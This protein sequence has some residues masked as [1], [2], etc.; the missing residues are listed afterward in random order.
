MMIT[1]DI[2]SFKIK[3]LLEFAHKS[4]EIVKLK[5]QCQEIMESYG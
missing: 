2:P 4:P 3:Y 5:Q 1:N